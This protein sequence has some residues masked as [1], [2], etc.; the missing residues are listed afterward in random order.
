MTS[1]RIFVAVGIGE[2]DGSV[3]IKA[4]ISSNV[5]SGVHTVATQDPELGA[6]HWGIVLGRPF[7]G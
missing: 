6:S 5:T 1:A 2:S 7:S 4:R 3:P